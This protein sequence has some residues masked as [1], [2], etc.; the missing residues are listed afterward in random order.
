MSKIAIGIDLGTTFSCVGVWKNNKVNIIQNNLG[1]GVTPSV[2]AFQ[3]QRRF[4]GQSA[5]DKLIK[6]YNSVV[7][8]SKRFIGRR[9]TDKE[10]Q[11][12]IQNYPFK[13]IESK[14]KKCSVKIEYNNEIKE[15][16]IEQISAMILEEMKKIAEIYMGAEIKDAIITVPAYFNEIQRECTKDAGRIA[17]LNVLR[18]INEPTAAAIAYGLENKSDKERKVLVF[19]LGGGTFDVTVLILSKNNGKDDEDKFI[20]VK[21]TYGDSHLG[22]EDFVKCL[23]KFCI[24]K[25]KK[26]NDIDISDNGKAKRRLKVACEK[27]KII[28]SSEQE[29]TIEIPNIAEDEDMDITILRT[30]FED[31]CQE[32]FDKCIS[33]V[34]KALENAEIKKE[35][36]DDIVLVGGSTRIP[37]IQEMVKLFFNRKQLIQNKGVNPDEAVAYGASYL[38][39]LING[40]INEN[41]LLLIDII[42]ISLGISDSKGK[43]EV[44][45]PKGTPIPIKKSKIFKISGNK[46]HKILVKV[47]QGENELCK[48]NYF[49]REFTINIKDTNSKDTKVEVIFEVNVNSIINITANQIGTDNNL[50][51]VIEDVNLALSQEELKVMIDDAKTMRMLDKKVLEII[52]LKN[53]LLNKCLKEKN[54]KKSEEIINWIKQNDNKDYIFTKE[55]LLEKMKQLN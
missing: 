4:V 22:G 40:Q 55:E 18:I 5:K 43:M 35:N 17:G 21:S 32:L 36:I 16:Q 34:K 2:V 44:I 23:M 15:F 1:N 47:Y 42:G 3:G 37:K 6:N 28:L 46:F 10:V 14:T 51:I 38:A 25:F 12:D 50:N 26:E 49:L 7:F 24:E 45:I 27:A 29:T 52:S 19:D 39:S 48:D 30:D 33:C 13:M 11:E 8:D 41:E 20:Q 31:C 9:F 53:E 54:N